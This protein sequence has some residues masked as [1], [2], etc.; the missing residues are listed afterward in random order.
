VPTR[1]PIGSFVRIASGLRAAFPNALAP[2]PPY[3]IAA[4]LLHQR[5][6]AISGQEETPG[7]VQFLLT[8]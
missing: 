6:S 8:F 1:F 3:Q 2:R 5:K 7:C 4:D